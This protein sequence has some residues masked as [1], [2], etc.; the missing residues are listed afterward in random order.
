MELV[1]RNVDD[2]TPR[3]RVRPVRPRIWM[4]TVRIGFRIGRIRI[5]VGRTRI[6]GIRL[7]WTRIGMRTRI[8]GIRLRRTRIGMRMRIVG[9]R[10]GRTRIGVRMR[11]VGIRLRRMRIGMRM[12][13]FLL[14]FRNYKP[15][16]TAG[17]KGFL[18]R[19]T[20]PAS[21]TGSGNTPNEDCRHYENRTEKSET[22][23]FHSMSLLSLF[24]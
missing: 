22:V 2:D 5:H 19:R 9:I 6:V 3:K 23:P 18:L 7:R 10:L 21:C 24:G 14:S 15:P 8:V 11:I 17:G 20:P 1:D 4:R 13:R 12:M 16:G